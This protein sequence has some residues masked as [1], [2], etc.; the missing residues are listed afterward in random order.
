MVVNM[1]GLNTAL[2]FKAIITPFGQKTK[3]GIYFKVKSL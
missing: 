2:V 3:V 1:N